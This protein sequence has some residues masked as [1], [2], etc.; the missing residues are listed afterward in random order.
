VGEVR[1][2][3]PGRIETGTGTCRVEICRVMTAA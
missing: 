2:A 3:G 1:V